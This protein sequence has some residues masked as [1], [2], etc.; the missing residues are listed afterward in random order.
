MLYKFLPPERVDVL[1]ALR[2]RFT[3]VVSLNDPFECLLKI[4][5]KEYEL[6]PRD[7]VNSVNFV[8]LSRN[9]KN[10]LMWAHYADCHKG[11]VVAFHRNHR[12]FRDSNSVRYR[13]QRLD[14]NGAQPHRLTPEEITKSITLEKAVDWA[15]EEEERLFLED[16]PKDIMSV[17]TDHWQQPILLNSFPKASLAAVYLGL[18]ASEDLIDR[19]ARALAENGIEIPIYRAKAN[20]GEFSLTFDELK[21]VANKTPE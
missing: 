21:P 9:H 6:S 20:R 13:R 14:L 12:Y 5:E 1:E 8:S 16:V 7:A 2:I 17:G 11:F 15:Y 18:R 4:G 10:L 3:S 19:I